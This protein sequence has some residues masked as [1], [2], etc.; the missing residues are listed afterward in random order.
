MKLIEFHKQYPDE[1]SCR[2]AFKEMREKEG[3]V[4]KKCDN[5]TPIVS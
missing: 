2:V 1:Q 3:I 4:C 5:T